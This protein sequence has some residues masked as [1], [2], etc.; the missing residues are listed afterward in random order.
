MSSR[1]IKLHD[2]VRIKSM[3][4]NGVV[5]DLHPYPEGTC[6]V[7]REGNEGPV[8]FNVPIRDIEIIE[9]KPIPRKKKK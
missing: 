6:D 1:P 4:I 5:V 8:Y 9:Q 2:Y 3:Q 7:E